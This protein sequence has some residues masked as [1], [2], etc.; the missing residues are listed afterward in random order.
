MGD[1]CDSFAAQGY[2][3]IA[4]ALYDRGAKNRVYGYDADGREGGRQCYGALSREVI[5]ADVEATAEALRQA[6]PVII[7]GFCSGGTWAWISAAELNFDA[8]VIFYGS[9][10]P[11]RLDYTPRCP[12]IMHYGDID[13]T[14]PMA[15]IDAIRQAHPGLT[16]Y[17]YPGAQ[18]AFFNPEQDSYD[19]EAAALAFSRSI[20]FM[21]RQFATA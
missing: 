15:D 16:Y 7:S 21:D 18:H 8:A 19:T 1:V 14:V 12:T 10:V 20:N 6:G 5:L 2:A 4:P 9:H 17:I 13:A 11:A 3:A